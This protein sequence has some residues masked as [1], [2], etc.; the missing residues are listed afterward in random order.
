VDAPKKPVLIVA[1]ALSVALSAVG[2]Y[3]NLKP[4]PAPEA[5][6]GPA[7]AAP[8]PAA[9]PAAV[10]APPAAPAAP[11]APALPSLDDSDA[12]VRAKA[13]GLS[14]S[15][16]FASWL[17]RDSLL[18]R[19]AA[20]VD[21]LSRG[22][23]PRAGL[24]FLAPRGA[25]TVERRGGSLF[26]SR[27]SWAR[28]DAAARAASSVDAGAAARLTEGFLPLL[29]E[30]CREQGCAGTFREVLIRSIQDLLAAPVP[31]APPRLKEAEK[32][33]VYEFADPRLERL[34]G[35]Q[36]LLIRMGPRNQTAVQAKLRELARALGLPE[37]RLPAPSTR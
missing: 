11:A 15:P 27:R 2:L 4:R 33:I 10:P 13:S 6:P 34:N 35:A 14:R 7:P 8:A 36:K 22:R 37:D 29:D 23:A 25:F 24:A 20:A 16:L 9:A 32:G 19:A 3:L 31:A 18:R 28:W 1:G 5:A 30:A 17:K 12:A 21:V 26:P